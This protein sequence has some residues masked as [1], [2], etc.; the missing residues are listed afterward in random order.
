MKQRTW[1]LLAGVAVALAVLAGA[2]YVAL[3]LFTTGSLGPL[4]SAG[5]SATS[6][7]QGRDYELISPTELPPTQPDLS[8][9]V[10]AIQDQTFTVV[11]KAST[12]VSGSAVEVV[13]TTATQ[14][15][16]DSTDDNGLNI[17]D[18]NVQRHIEPYDAGLIKV[19]DGLIAWGDQRG[20]RLVA[21]VVMMEVP[22]AKTT[23]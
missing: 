8:G 20:N 10:S 2:S 12:G 15:Y 16:R 18:G 9:K 1:A 11:S 22:P 19:G 4:H 17:V 14:V 7:V 23:R 21:T 13:I 6:P 5:L 3:S